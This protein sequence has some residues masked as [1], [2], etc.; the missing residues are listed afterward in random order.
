MLCTHS[1]THSLI[2]RCAIGYLFSPIAVSSVVECDLVASLYIADGKK[3]D[4][5]L[6]IN[7][8]RIHV[9]IRIH[10]VIINQPPG[11]DIVTR[12]INPGNTRRHGLWYLS[13]Q[14]E[15]IPQGVENEKSS[16]YWSTDLCNKLII[17]R[18]QHTSCIELF[19]YKRTIINIIVNT[20]LNSIKL[21]TH[22]FR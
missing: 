2:F 11:G 3:S 20:L 15:N 14:D 8:Y 9:S 19:A 17:E 4:I 22:N 6:P 21:K 18:L 1:L 12:K 7:V 16:A 5:H 13:K 10:P